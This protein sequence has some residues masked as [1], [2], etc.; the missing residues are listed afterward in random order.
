MLLQSAI[1]YAT[2]M[3]SAL[4]AAHDQWRHALLDSSMILNLAMPS[5]FDHA[6]EFVPAEQLVRGLRISNEASQFVDWFAT[7][8]EIGFDAIY[9]HHIGRDLETFIETFAEQVL[10]NFAPRE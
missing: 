1:C 7:D 4:A 3:E 6:S 9:L 10:P 5:D 8:F 2:T